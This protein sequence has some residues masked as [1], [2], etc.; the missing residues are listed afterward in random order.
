VSCRQEREESDTPR[1]VRE[2]V[3]DA[4]P[5]PT[6]G[7]IVGAALACERLRQQAESLLLILRHAPRDQAAFSRLHN[8]ALTA[9]L[10]LD[11]AYS[12]FHAILE[13]EGQG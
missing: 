10:E 9:W 5:L 11:E 12:T 2:A 4:P 7:H 13:C 1:E 3:S 8:D 6:E